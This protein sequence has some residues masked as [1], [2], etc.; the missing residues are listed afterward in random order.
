M[1]HEGLPF[2][3]TIWVVGWSDRPQNLAFLKRVWWSDIFRKALAPYLD[4]TWG[5][6]TIESSRQFVPDELVS[7]VL[8][9]WLGRSRATDK[10]WDIFF[11]DDDSRQL[12][13]GVCCPTQTVTLHVHVPIW[14][15]FHQHIYVH[16]THPNPCWVELT[17]FP[18]LMNLNPGQASDLCSFASID[19]VLESCWDCT[20]L[21]WPYC[22]WFFQYFTDLSHLTTILHINTLIPVHDEPISTNGPTPQQ[23]SQAWIICD[24]LR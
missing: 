17:F 12:L 24:C 14:P 1:N 13:Q 23:I 21:V 15:H 11:T 5:N 10:F 3:T 8:D 2:S 22:M 18:V 16:G 6:L 7:G 20:T 19:Y 4:Q 9:Y